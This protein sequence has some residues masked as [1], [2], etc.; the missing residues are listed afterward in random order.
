[1]SDIFKDFLCGWTS[2]ITQVFVMQPF[3]IVKVRLINQSFKDSYYKG[4][5]DC[6]RKIRIEEGLL[7]FYRGSYDEIFRYIDTI[8][9]CWCTSIFTIC[10]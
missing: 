8:V 4:T 5:I 1:M 2:G 3:E 9:R 6:F 7:A 10:I